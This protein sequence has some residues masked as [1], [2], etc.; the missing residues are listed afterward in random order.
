METDGDAQVRWVP[1]AD[2]LTLREAMAVLAVSR[3]TIFRLMA[4]G[5]L[6][7]YEVEGVRGRRFRREDL[8]ALLRPGRDRQR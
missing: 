5:K 1:M 3:A 8:D 6:R 4:T 2:M 7:W